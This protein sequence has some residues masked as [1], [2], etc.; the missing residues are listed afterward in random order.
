[1]HNNPFTTPD[2]KHALAAARTR[3]TKNCKS[4]S[5]RE[6]C[7]HQT[8]KLGEEF[9]DRAAN[10]RTESSGG[11]GGVTEQ[12]GRRPVSP[13]TLLTLTHTRQKAGQHHPTLSPVCSTMGDHIAGTQSRYATSHPA[14]LSLLPSAGWETSTRQSAAML[15]IGHKCK[16]GSLLQWIEHVGG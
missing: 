5:T 2:K 10:K 13:V 15:S 6:Q 8:P 11:C 7:T 1:V 14:Q 16:Y 12:W 3:T 9:A 4:N